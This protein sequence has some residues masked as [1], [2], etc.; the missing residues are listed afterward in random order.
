MK[1]TFNIPSTSMVI[2]VWYRDGVRHEQL[3]S[4]PKSNNDLFNTMLMSHKV[5]YSE[6]RAVKAV[7][8][9]ELVNVNPFRHRSS[10]V[11]DNVFANFVTA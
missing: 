7:V 10:V 5:G 1:P 11:R 6:I 8:A 2:V 4:T 9:D 3:I